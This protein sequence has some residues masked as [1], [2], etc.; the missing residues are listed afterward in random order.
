MLVIYFTLFYV[1]TFSP[2]LMVPDKPQLPL[3]VQATLSTYTSIKTTYRKPSN[4][5]AEMAIQLSSHKPLD[6]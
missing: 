2:S 6:I 5:E 1:T 4:T 3:S